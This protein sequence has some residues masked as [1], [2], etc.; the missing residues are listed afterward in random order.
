ML[1]F[2]SL[3]RDYLPSWGG[4]D[5][6]HFRHLA[7]LTVRFDRSYVCSMP[8]MPARRDLHTG[9]SNFLFRGWG[10]LEPFDFSMPQAL[11]D[12]GIYTHFVTDHYHYWED[13]GAT[14]HTRY[15]SHQFI[16]GQEG[17][18]WIGQVAPPVIP[19]TL[20]FR[21]DD[22]NSRLGTLQRQDWV[23]RS[24]IRHKDQFPQVLTFD[25]GLDFITTNASQDNWFLQIETFDPHEPFYAPPELRQLEGVPDVPV[26]DWPSYRRVTESPEELDLLRRN[27]RALLRLCDDQLGR[28][29]DAFDRHDLWKDTM[30]IVWTDHGFLLGEHGCLAK[31]WCP[32]YQPVANT[33]FF[34]W[35]PRAGVRGQSRQALIQPSIDL[36]PTLLNYFGLPIPASVRGADLLPAIAQDTPLRQAAIFG[37]FGLE[38]NVTDG[39]YVYMREPASTAGPIY[40]DTLMPTHMSRMFTRQ[41][42]N[43]WV[44][45]AERPYSNGFRVPRYAAGDFPW[46]GAPPEP[47]RLFDLEAD[48]LQHHPL[49]HPEA[50]ARMRALLIQE[51]RRHDA[52][53]WQFRRL[54]LG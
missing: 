34:I 15:H 12:A 24:R 51:M 50:E 25:A 29:L 20:N 37:C 41:Q 52:P 53:E 45:T 28:L 2:D 4:M 22:R 10:P 36:A 33:P 5:L 47:H 30:L 8:C 32:F 43:A 48:P 6:P 42:I 11:K 38:V 17:D 3:N 21:E 27:Y 35:D 14:Y 49:D 40:A 23:N 31:V 1:M 26:F 9:R 18:G 13:G 54:G 19:P 46:M 39:R 7:D 44:E 16:R